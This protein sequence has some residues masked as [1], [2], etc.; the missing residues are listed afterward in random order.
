MGMWCLIVVVVLVLGLNYL[1]KKKF[2][3]EAKGKTVL[4]RCK[5]GM[6]I[7]FASGQITAA[8]PTIIPA[9]ALPKNFKTVVEASQLLNMNLFTFVPMGCFTEEFSYY[10]KTL[11]LTVPVIVAVGGL[12]SLGV[13]RK[14]PH[15]F[16]AGDA[17]IRLIS[18]RVRGRHVKHTA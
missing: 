10:M 1:M 9:V 16:T 8:L 18:E 5:N 11:A 2:G 3:R 6:K 17:V 14:R 12:I 4:K 15:L 7:L 13:V